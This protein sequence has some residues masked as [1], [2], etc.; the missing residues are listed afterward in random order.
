MLVI[1]LMVLFFL[2]KK[3][4]FQLVEIL[5]IPE[6]KFDITEVIDYRFYLNLF[7]CFQINCK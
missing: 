7:S 4:I 5:T 3:R 2:K 1:V 6:S